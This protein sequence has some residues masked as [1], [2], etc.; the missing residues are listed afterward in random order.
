[1]RTL[2]A[3]ALLAVAPAFV[4]IACSPRSSDTGKPASTTPAAP[5]TVASAVPLPA[6]SDFVV[7]A[8]QGPPVIAPSVVG[9]NLQAAQD[10]A[11]AASLS[12]KSYDALGQHRIQVAAQDWKVCS[13]IPATGM[14]LATGDRLVLSTVRIEES[15]P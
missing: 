11:R 7:E 5:A 1:M 10:E 9:K 8:P 13:Q 12:F 6:R 2:H 4:L 3:V 14:R 15:C